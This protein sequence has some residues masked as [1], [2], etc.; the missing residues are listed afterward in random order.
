MSRY[1]RCPTC[2][3]DTETIQDAY[4][5]VGQRGGRDL[6]L[7]SVCGTKFQKRSRRNNEALPETVEPIAPVEPPAK[8]KNS[9]I[10]VS[11]ARAE[12]SERRSPGKKVRNQRS[13]AGA[14]SEATASEP[15]P[16]NLHNDVGWVYPPTP[17]KYHFDWEPPDLGQEPPSKWRRKWNETVNMF[18]YFRLVNDPVPPLREPGP[19]QVY[20]GLDELLE[21]KPTEPDAI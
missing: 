21:L 10:R 19:A 5:V 1:M 2:P 3:V 12:R 18:K 9:V 15:N 6:Y 14:A 7:C 16:I 13:L 20:R 4:E 8:A 17:D 11:E